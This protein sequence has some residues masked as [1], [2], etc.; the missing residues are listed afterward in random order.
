MICLA[1]SWL[2]GDVERI[3]SG[4]FHVKFTSSGHETTSRLCEKCLLGHV[5]T[6]SNVAITSNIGQISRYYS[7]KAAMNIE[8]IVERQPLVDL[9]M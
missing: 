7:S 2:Q 1:S 6:V 3:S 8:N 5:T 9:P 4:R